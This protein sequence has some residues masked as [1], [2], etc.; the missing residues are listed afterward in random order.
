VYSSD[1]FD[2]MQR[3]IEA[4][5]QAGAAG[6][7][8]GV[9]RP[10]GRVDVERSRA[11]IEVAYPMKTTFHRAFDTT[12]DLSE[13]LEAVIQTGAGC[14][15]TSGGHTNVLA[16]ADRIGQLRAQA[17]GRLNVMAGGGLTLTN[18]A[19]VVQKSG[20]TYLHGSLS[21]T[22]KNRESAEKNTA[23]PCVILEADV[24]E[25]IRLFD[26]ALV[27]R[28]RDLDGRDEP[29]CVVT[30]SGGHDSSG[31]ARLCGRPVSASQAIPAP[32]AC[33]HLPRTVL[34]AEKLWDGTRLLDRPIVVIED[35]RI[36]SIT[37]RSASEIPFPAQVLDFPGA[38]L[39]PAFLDVHIHGA[40]GH[41]IMEATPEALNAIGAFLASHG[42]G[43][44]LPTTVTAPLDATLRALSGLA[45]LL[46]APAADGH[47]RPLGIHLEGPFL[48]QLKRGVHPLEHL[49][50]PDIAVFDRLFEAA[51]GH[52]RLMT[53][54]P[55]MPGAVELATHATA[56]GVRIS[57]GH[58]NA[59]AAETR[60]GI[61]AG[62]VSATHTFNAMRALDHREPGILGTVLTDDSLFAELVCD[63]IHVAPE[64]VKLW[65]RAKGPERAILMTDALSAAGMPDGHYLLGGFAFEV[66]GGRAMANG[67]LAG[68]VLTLDRALANLIAFTGAPLAQ[69]LRLVTTNPASM[70]GL[71][72]QAGSLAQGQPANLVAV[73]AK[74]KLLA[75]LLNGLPVAI[76]QPH[77]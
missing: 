3:Q 50:T 53:L 70:T 23:N 45:K 71:G 17:G 42:T 41:D 51:E 43:S 63:G 26:R 47:A 44:F 66:A 5:K 37:S 69:A 16:G 65:W 28:E 55:E 20:V 13:A 57:V 67:V 75:S 6:V 68:S 35:G 18:L 58:S 61:A 2:Q 21:Y 48:S 46:D 74:G 1:E 77:S 15:L 76:L 34:T 25:A 40:A 62:A 22:Q 49:L 60:A 19:E 32:N 38:T 29:A 8:L 30:G 36:A 56:R 33:N 14:L 73:D 24:R 31:S 10:D 27:I 39:A 59:T 64:M 4:A 72:D 7:V 54:A 52:V 12:P 11:L 9:L